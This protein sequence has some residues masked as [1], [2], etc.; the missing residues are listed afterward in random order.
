MRT[1]RSAS[2][3]VIAVRVIHAPPAGLTPLQAMT[4]AH[5]RYCRDMDFRA[6]F[7][8][9]RRGYLALRGGG[10]AIARAC[11]PGERDTDLGGVVT[12]GGGSNPALHTSPQGGPGP[13]PGG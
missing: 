1:N 6:S 13:P 11:G 8:G 12:L 3:R 2:R 4:A 10:E 9:E 7:P 5:Q